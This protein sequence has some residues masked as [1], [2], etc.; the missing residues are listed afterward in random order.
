MTTITP[1]GAGTAAIFN[2]ISNVNELQAMVTFGQTAT[3]FGMQTVEGTRIVFHGSGFGAY[4][5]NFSTTGTITSVDVYEWDGVSAYVQTSTWTL[6]P[7]VLAND[8]ATAVNNPDHAAGDAAFTGALFGSADTMTGSTDDDTLIGYG[9]NDTINGGAGGDILAGG[10]GDDTV[11]GEG[12]DDFLGIAE[13]TEGDAYDGGANTDTL[14]ITGI[15]AGNVNINATNAM[16]S[17]FERIAF[18]PLSGVGTTSIGVTFSGEQFGAGFIT[19]TALLVI[20]SAVTDSLTIRDIIGDFD[21]SSWTF[22]WS[23]GDA[24]FLGGD[25]G[26]NILTTKA[27][28]AATLIGYDGADEVHGGNLTDN[29]YGNTVADGATDDMYGGN[30]GD[31]YNVYELAD[32]IH[33]LSG[34]TGTDYA[35]VAVNNY[36]LAANVE[37]MALFGA[38]VVVGTGNGL[39]NSIQGNTALGDTLSGLGGADFIYGNGGN[40]TLIGGAAGDQLNG[41][42][43]STPPPTRRPAREWSS[44]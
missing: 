2:D 12:G 4:S 35:A 1:F 28:V 24:L 15:V 44:I 6:S 22:A 30:G 40:D 11:N 36:V 10:A 34:D 37:S 19:S 13:N 42:L 16:F 43:E 8:L 20:G 31:V 21:V 14:V 5:G 17:N 3:D 25:G 9:G 7:N 32:I 23:A 26:A 41:A 33:E 29:L 39:G 38:G 27:T 18:A